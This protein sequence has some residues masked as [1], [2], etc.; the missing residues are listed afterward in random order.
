MSGFRDII[1]EKYIEKLHPH[2]YTIVVYTQEVGKN[3]KIS[4]S[5]YGIF[6]PGTTFI[7][8]NNILSN[9]ISCI[10]IQRVKSFK[11]EKYI[12]GLSN[13]NVYNGKSNLCEYYEN[14]YHNPTTYDVIEKFLNVYNPIELIFIHNLEEN[15]F[16]NIKNF[17]QLKCKKHY[18]I[19]L[20]DKE[21]NLTKQAINCE[22]QVYQNE[23]IK[24][25][26]PTINFEVFKYKIEDKPIS[27]QS[28]CFLLNFVSQ[29]NVNLINK[30][31]EPSVEQIKNILYCANHSLRQLNM[32][33]DSDTFY[34]NEEKINSVLSILND[35]K[36]K[37]GKRET[38]EILLNPINDKQEL[39]NQYTNIEYLK[40]K[41][42]CFDDNLSKIKDIDKLITKL[43]INKIN[44]CDIFTLHET[45][46]IYDIMTKPVK[47]DKKIANIFNIKEVNSKSKEFTQ[48]LQN[49]FNIKVCSQ[50]YSNNFDK[51]EDLCEVLFKQGNFKELDNI[52]KDKFDS[53]DKLNVI[54]D[55]IEL[56]F[57][58]KD[59]DKSSF[60][61]QHQPASGEL[62]ILLQK[63]EEKY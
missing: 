59:K 28:Y 25:F 47:K 12:F 41:I 34:E 13:I 5:Q 63:R 57:D 49:L 11:G 36:T 44:P 35:C 37:M 15:I 61:K 43:K 50:I 10:W 30:I 24:G 20:N 33:N 40:N 18:N 17:L 48:Y 62:C 4:R 27:L 39:R 6:S 60:I 3:G 14:Y 42:E 26:F 46:K 2:G 19:D 16:N 52:I 9:N 31:S 45:Q 29:H 7:E 51:Y 8:N 58:K 32:I 56:L 55:N 22:N 1:L 54:L 38:N 21:H 23:I 53:K